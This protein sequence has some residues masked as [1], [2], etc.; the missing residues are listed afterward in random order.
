VFNCSKMTCTMKQPNICTFL[1]NL[2]TQNPKPI[3][4][5]PSIAIQLFPRTQMMGLIPHFRKLGW[6]SLCPWL[7]LNHLFQKWLKHPSYTK[8]HVIISKMW[9]CDW[10]YS[11]T[12]VTI[13]PFFCLKFCVDY[14]KNKYEKRIFNHF[15]FL[16]RGRLWKCG[17]LYEH[18]AYLL[19][20]VSCRLASVFLSYLI[21]VKP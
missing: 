19:T 16:K 9:P 2:K 6:T 11:N 17:A 15:L 14:V 18:V 8:I 5:H 13:S 21:L 3:H 1:N 10:K 12:H 4:M 20:F 7:V